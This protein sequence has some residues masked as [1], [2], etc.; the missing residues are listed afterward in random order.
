MTFLG[1]GMRMSFGG[2]MYRVIFFYFSMAPF[3]FP[4]GEKGF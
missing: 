4:K 3:S 2:I 1:L